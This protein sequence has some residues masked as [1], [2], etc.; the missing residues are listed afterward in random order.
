MKNSTCRKLV[1]NLYANDTLLPNFRQ[2]FY[3]ALE[4]NTVLTHLSMSHCELSDDLVVPL[5]L[6]LVENET[7]STLRLNSNKRLT[8]DTAKGIIKV[9]NQSNETLKKLHLDRTGVSKKSIQK[10]NEVLEERDDKKRVAK[11]QEERQRK[12]E[13]LLAADSTPQEEETGDEREDSQQSSS[14]RTRDSQRSSARSIR[15]RDSQRS[16]AKSKASSKKEK[17]ARRD[18][19][20]ESLQE[21]RSKSRNKPRDRSSSQSSRRSGL[22]RQPSRQPGLKKCATSSV[23]MSAKAKETAQQM[24]QLGGDIVDVGQDREKLR[25][26]RRLR[27][28]CETCGQRCF[29]K[30]LFK[31]T[32]LS[33]PHLV[34]EGRCLKCNP[35]M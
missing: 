10:L 32:P 11:L 35:I 26:T 7:L 28:E 9:L 27:G 25:E 21:D 22:S 31:T 33:I 17:S 14:I 1:P 8:D 3:D 19:R 15:T 2:A 5:I 23:R 20:S 29:S 30:T 16:S 4:E 13:A 12:I 18:G 34:R 24:A 6:A